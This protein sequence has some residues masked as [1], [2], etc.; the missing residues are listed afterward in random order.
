VNPGT[1]PAPPADL[2]RR[3]VTLVNFAD[4]FFRTHRINL[5]P[6]HYG[7]RCTSRFDDPNQDYG[8]LYAGVDEFCAF[9]E[10]FTR[11]AGIQIVSTTALEQNALSRLTTDR[12]IRLVDL[13][14]SGSLV[15]IG[16]DARLFSGDHSTSRLWSRALHDLPTKPDGILYPSRLD[17]KRHALAIFEDRAPKIITLNRESWFAPGKMRILLAKVM[18]HYTLDL[19]ENRFVAQRKP[20]SSTGRQGQLF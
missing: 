10:T 20:P 5:N 2:A 16:A 4:P 15:R 11:A 13:T 7:K 9:I 6:V 19:I 3:R 1:L 17:P 12:P 8:V 14:Q 18:Q